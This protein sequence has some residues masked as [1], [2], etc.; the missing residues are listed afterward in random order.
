MAAENLEVL[1]GLAQAAADSYD[2]AIDEDGN[3]VEIGLKREDK[4]QYKKNVA[5]GFKVRFAHNKAIISYHSEVMLKEV[6]PR[7]QFENEIEGVFKDIVKHLKKRYS[8][9][10]TNSVSLTAEG[11]AD[12]HV[13]NLSRQKNGP[14]LQRFGQGPS[15]RNP[16]IVKS[17]VFIWL[18][19]A[20]FHRK[21]I[22]NC[23]FKN[24]IKIICFFKS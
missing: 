21:I 18:Y 13:Q 5:D 11:D 6:H 20:F 23:I 10:T 2:G 8:Q 14:I 1:R 22:Q 12:I 7:A 4:N 16:E 3:P 19:E 24:R 17:S 15:R 9:I